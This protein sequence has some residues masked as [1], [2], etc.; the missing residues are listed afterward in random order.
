MLEMSK[1]AISLIEI[2]LA[3][4]SPKKRFC[5]DL[6]LTLVTSSTTNDYSTVEPIPEMINLLR[7]LKKHGHHI[8]IYTARRM[9]THQGNIGLVIADVGLITLETLKRLDIPYDEI[10]FGKPQADFY[11]DDKAINPWLTVE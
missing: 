5:F 11:I 1:S 9:R 4:D 2:H 7:N 8:I 10:Y 3:K 6:D